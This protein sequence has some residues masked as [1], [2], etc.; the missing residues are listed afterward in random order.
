MRPTFPWAR[1]REQLT[2]VRRVQIIFAV[3]GLIAVTAP[4]PERLGDRYQVALPILALGCEVMNGSGLEYVGR[5][6]VMFVGMH[7]TKRALGLNPMNHRPKGGLEGFPSGHTATATFGATSLIQSCV[8]K[9][10]V[11]QIA[12]ALAAGYTGGSRIETRWHTLTQVM[13]GAIWGILCSM[14]FRKDTAARR[15]ISA[16]LMRIGG[17]L[18]SGRTQGLWAATGFPTVIQPRLNLFRDWAIKAAPPAWQAAKAKAKAFWRWFKVQLD[19][20]DKPEPPK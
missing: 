5:Y 19:M 14:A 15:N 1:L 10:P 20:H 6:A 16:W 3:L 17:R 11:A 9:A 7:A 8:T 2:L 18:G 12:V 13:A 4:S